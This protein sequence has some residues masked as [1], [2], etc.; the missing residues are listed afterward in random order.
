MQFNL[1][2][3]D[4]QL[5]HQE[6]NMIKENKRKNIKSSIQKTDEKKEVCDSKIKEMQ[7][8]DFKARQSREQDIKIEQSK[9]D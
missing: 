4:N 6:Q 7:E 1:I 5:Q 3:V 8:R 2:K 9:R